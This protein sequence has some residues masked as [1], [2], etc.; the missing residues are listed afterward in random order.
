MG[1]ACENKRNYIPIQ[2][3]FLLTV[4][5]VHQALRHFLSPCRTPCHQE[6]QHTVPSIVLK[7][8]SALVE[9]QK[10]ILGIASSKM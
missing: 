2:A 6:S 7:Q 5:L 3:V 10:T 1:S 9:K 8:G 4:F